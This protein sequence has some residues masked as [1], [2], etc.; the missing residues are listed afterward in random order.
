MIHIL[1]KIMFDMLPLDIQE[2]IHNSLNVRDQFH[3]RSA[4]RMKIRAPPK[5]LIEKKLKALH[6]LSKILKKQA[7][8]PLLKEF[9]CE[10]RRFVTTHREDPTVEDFV[11]CVDNEEDAD[12]ANDLDLLERVGT[13]TLQGL[14]L[15]PFVLS[16]VIIDSLPQAVYTKATPE[17][18]EILR[19][20]NP[21]IGNFL[22]QRNPF[23]FI[24]NFENVA[25]LKH[26]LADASCA[27]SLAQFLNTSFPIVGSRLRC[28]MVMREA[29]MSI[30]LEK[31]NE[32]MDVAL[33]NL[34]IDVYMFYKNQIPAN[35]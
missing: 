4:V 35:D 26:C 29:G 31:C 8:R 34:D 19:K 17:T 14:D 21:E 28:C 5:P 11:Q 12:T 22:M 32:M 24:I 10:I 9:P 13:N 3:L 20:G 1:I 30:P 6:V 16:K 18:F 33:G 23:F 25:L 15:L 7:K 27:E 2:T